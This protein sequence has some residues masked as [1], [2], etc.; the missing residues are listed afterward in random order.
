MRS[1]LP[2]T[3]SL[4]LAACGGQPPA[5]P[6]PPG[7]TVA[8]VPERDI[9]EWDEFTGRVE[10]VDAVEIRPRV[11]GYIQRVAFAEGSEVRKGDV[12]F[13]IDPRPYAADLARAE[14]QVEVARTR[15]QLAARDVVRAGRLVAVQA[16]S[17]EEF[18][19]RTAGQAEGEAA[20]RAAEADAATAR[21]NLEWTR[22]RSPISGRVGRAEV[23]E[24]NLVQ[25]G[26]PTATLLTTVVSL[27]PIYVL[28]EGDEQTYLKYTLLARSGARPS[29]RDRRN[30]VYIGL[31]NEEGFPHEGYVDF[32][33][34][35]L[36]PE[37]GTIRARAVL[38]NK[39]RYFTPGLFARVK[40]VGSGRYRT[41]L[42]QD[43][44]VGTDQDKKFVLVLKPDS[45]V[46]YRAVQI[47]RLVDG[48]RI[49]QKGVAPGERIVVNGLQR[50]RPGMKVTPT[51]AAMD[52]N[53]PAVAAEA[54]AA[55]AAR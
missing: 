26:P 43:R 19:S 1:V 14:A 34:N 13:V 17:K 27:D 5:P 15:A 30:Q 42:I 51:L 21:L 37:S 40:L 4:A 11:S 10:A 2:V 31:A 55:A 23:T 8:E 24:G 16:I 28:F 54:P 6:P 35:Q 50:V 18:D 36:N 7:V 12:L 38:S 53:P 32:V 29:S 22:V 41:A 46:E 3:L 9:N 45:T 49:V 20:V 48:L 39:E 33:D 52:T 25:A 44:A 47:G